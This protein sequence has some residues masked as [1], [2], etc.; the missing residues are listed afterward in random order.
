[1]AAEWFAEASSTDDRG[2][3][4]HDL[5]QNLGPDDSGVLDGRVLEFRR[6][7]KWTWVW[8]GGRRKMGR[9]ECA[10][11]ENGVQRKMEM[12]MTGTKVFVDDGESV[13]LKM[14]EEGMDW[15]E[16]DFVRGLR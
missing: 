5:Q 8:N 12:V 10:E 15:I 1:M 13:L 7:I 9:S 6:M 11:N 3:L 16:M 14:E 2:R 4:R